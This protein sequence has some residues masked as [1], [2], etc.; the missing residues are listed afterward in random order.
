MTG[1]SEY[2]EGIRSNFSIRSSLSQDRTAWS[3]N[4]N[5]SLFTSAT[6]ARMREKTTEKSESSTPD[7][8]RRFWCMHR[9]IEKSYWTELTTAGRIGHLEIGA[10]TRAEI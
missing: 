3:T 4:R 6:E 5:P 7:R 9:R 1:C 8:K 10:Q 2:F